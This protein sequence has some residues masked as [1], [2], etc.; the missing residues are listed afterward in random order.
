MMLGGTGVD[1]IIKNIE[2]GHSP[3]LSRPEKLMEMVIEL[4]HVFEAL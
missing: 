1:W 2:S 4:A 3:Q